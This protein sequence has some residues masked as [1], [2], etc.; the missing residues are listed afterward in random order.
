MTI[1]LVLKDHGFMIFRLVDGPHAISIVVLMRA[2]PE[3][4]T[5]HYFLLRVI[6]IWHFILPFSVECPFVLVTIIL[7]G[8][9]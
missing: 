5:I 8:S 4:S 6:G 1:F 7:I 2:E 3:S 9:C